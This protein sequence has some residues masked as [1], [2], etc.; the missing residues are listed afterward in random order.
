MIVLPRPP[1]R[2]RL[3]AFANPRYSY[4]RALEYELLPSIPLK[5]RVLDFGGGAKAGYLDLL[6]GSTQY[7]SLNIDPDMQPTMLHDANTPF[8]IADAQ[9]DTI[10]SFNTLEHVYRDEFALSELLRVLKP[11]GTIHII[12]P[13]IYRVHASPSDFHRH[14]S[15]WWET[16]LDRYGIPPANSRIEPMMWGRMTTAFSFL[17]FTRLRFMRKLP[18]WG[19]IYIKGLGV[20]ENPLGYYVSG[21]KP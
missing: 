13:F 12:V 20:H 15:F 17:E 8:P 2:A 21:T 6:K 14:T 5:G 1:S 9:Y 11:G 4:L 7:E 10:V 18:L 3:A 19:D 16:T